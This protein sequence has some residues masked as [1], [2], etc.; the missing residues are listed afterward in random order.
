ML[1]AFAAP[2]ITAAADREYHVAR[3]AGGTYRLSSAGT[4]LEFADADR[5][6]FY[7]DKNITIALQHLRPDLLFVHGAAI[8]WQGRV[9]VL[10]APPGTGKSTLVLTALRSGFQYLS[11]ELAP[12]DLRDLTVFPYPRAL[13]LKTA[14]PGPHPLPATA[15]DHGG[16][17]H[18]PA[19]A[20]TAAVP[21]TA[22]LAAVMFLRRDGERFS[23]LRP[24]STASAAAHLLA[25][26]LN[27]LSHSAAGMDAVA[28]VSGA[29]SC[30]ELDATDLIAA[31]EA[32][33]TQ[34]ERQVS[35]D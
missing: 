29:V 24:L 35:L 11:D 17:Y 3:T 33:R 1:G 2:P 6:L 28:A 21:R 30:Y 8:A 26:S 27:L 15:I 34:L 9:A 23:G 5:F 13:Y 14:P 4:T 31:S 12:I 25:N 19:P 10:A 18:V 20:G 7:L 16:R 22:P 32:M